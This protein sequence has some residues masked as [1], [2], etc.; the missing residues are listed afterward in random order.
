MT[1]AVLIPAV[2]AAGI[3]CAPVAQANT[4]QDQ[5]FIAY[6]DSHNVSQHISDMNTAIAAGHMACR[7]LAQ[8]KDEIS[9]E[10]DVAGAVSGN[11]SRADASW[12]IGAAKRAFCP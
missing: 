12:I 5:M 8:G 9:T 11:V 4:Q 2:L 1:K 7:E 10:L 3:A 6:L